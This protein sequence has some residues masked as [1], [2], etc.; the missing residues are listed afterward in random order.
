[1]ALI[2]DDRIA[3]SATNIP[4]HMEQMIEILEQEEQEHGATVRH[5]YH[6]T[7]SLIDF[8]FLAQSNSCNSDSNK[9]DLLKLHNIHQTCIS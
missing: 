3:V 9:L 4:M 8:L 5:L 7:I 6:F 1:M 2:S